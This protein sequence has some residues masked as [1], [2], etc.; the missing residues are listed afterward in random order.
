MEIALEASVPT[1]AG[2]LGIL[3]G[4]TLRSAADIGLPMA[5]VTLLHRKGYFEQH[6]DPAGNQSETPSTWNPA[7]V[8]QP[9]D[10]RVWLILEGQ[11]IGLRACNTRSKAAVVIESLSMF[12]T[13]PSRKIL[14][15]LKR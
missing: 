1:Y 13:L 7:D 15:T 2:G 10:A 8:L 14:P 5:G 9:L 12:L 11:R 6:L 3:A 4:D